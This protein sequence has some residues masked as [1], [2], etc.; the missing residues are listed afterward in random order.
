MPGEV[1]HLFTSPA[2]AAPMAPRTSAIARAGRGLDGDRYAE[3]IGHFSD[4]RPGRH[5]TLVA[6]EDIEVANA[7]L[8]VPLT[9]GDTRR[10]VVTRGIDLRSL[11]GRRFRIG[12]VECVA[13]RHCPPCTYLDGLLGRTVLGALTDRGGIRADILTG[14]MIH[15]GD[16]IGVIEEAAANEHQPGVSASTDG[17]GL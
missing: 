17:S 2:A 4:D 8:A 10:N 15:V 3:S 14:G 6:I 12:G 13:V 16:R 1:L 7:S 11:L 9:P 5:L